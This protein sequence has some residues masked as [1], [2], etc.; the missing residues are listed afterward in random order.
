[1]AF[2]LLLFEAPA[3]LL[4]GL[5]PNLHASPSPRLVHAPQGSVREHFSFR[6]RQARQETGWRLRLVT[7]RC[8]SDSDW[9]RKT[10]VN[11]AMSDMMGRVTRPARSGGGGEDGGRGR[12]E[13]FP[14]RDV[15][16][17]V[18]LTIERCVKWMDQANNCFPRRID[19]EQKRLELN[20]GGLSSEGM[21]VGIIMVWPGVSRGYPGVRTFRFRKGLLR[22]PINVVSLPNNRRSFTFASLLLTSE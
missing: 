10:E 5:G 15:D 14:I 13:E 19:I 2:T 7:L 6:A 4:G 22:S 18:I 16:V 3:L 9:A 21:M 12:G 17:S 1:M 20:S 8:W 11:W